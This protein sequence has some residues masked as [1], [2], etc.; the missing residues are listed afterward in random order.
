MTAATTSENKKNS[1]FSVRFRSKFSEDMKLFIT[2]LVFQLL[3]LPVF[4]G[5]LIWEIYQDNNNLHDRASSIPFVVIAVIALF[6]STGMGLVIPM[7]NFRYLYNKSLVDMNYSLP[8][9]NRQRFFAD[10]LSGLTA[11]IAPF[12][13]G[14]VISVIEL[15]IGSCF[16][17]IGDITPY[18]PSVIQVG[19]II[20]VGLIM[21][22]T[23]AV[24]AISFAGSTFEALFGIVAVNIMI[25]LFIFLTW[26][27]IVEA[28][29]FGL[30]SK[31][32][33][34][35][36]TLFTTSPIGVFVFIIAF[37]ERVSVPEY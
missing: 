15:L 27:N 24:F 30:T 2:N 14:A 36:F 18:I 26:S 35:N 1:F 19:S 7:I 31:S 37:L 17:D 8:L 34:T 11:Y 32:V 9:N 29:H 3:C 22:Y 25:P 13:I 33:E 5:I 23:I 28:A 12:L 21:L 16:V 6:L 4:A 10:Y 20:I